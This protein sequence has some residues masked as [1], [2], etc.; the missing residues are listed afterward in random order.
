MLIANNFLM[1]VITFSFDRHHLLY[2]SYHIVRKDG[3]FILHKEYGPFH[4]IYMVEVLL[5]CL[6]MI[7]ITLWHI[8]EKRRNRNWQ[9][10]E[11]LLVA[12]CPTSCYAAEKI[13]DLP[14]DVIPYGLAASMLMMLHLVYFGKIYDLYS[15]VREDVFDTTD[16]ALVVM[17]E[18]NHYKGSNVLAMS[19]IP[20]LKTATIGENIEQISDVFDKILHED[21]SRI[22]FQ[23]KI[24]ESDVRKIERYNQ[25]FGQVIWLRDVTEQRNYLQFCQNYQQKLK[26]EVNRKTT[27]LQ[28][29]QEKMILGFASVIESRDHITGGHVKRT[30]GYVNILVN[31]VKDKKEF[32]EFQDES[33]AK[34]VCLA[35]PL[36]DIGKIGIP[37]AI[38]N[39]KGKFEP[40][41]YEIMK[42]HADLGSEILDK[43]L[44][45][46]EDKE[47]YELAKMM[48]GCHHERWD[49]T[50]YPNQMRGTEIPICARIMAVADVFDALTSERPY[51]REFSVGEAFEII[52]EGR[53]TQFDPDVVDAFLEA[54]DEIVRFHDENKMAKAG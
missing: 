46:L 16:T 7:V 37:D 26:E 18:K 45:S 13:F 9:S 35:A 3:F 12:L 25:F 52:K 14:Y 48:A 32:A 5:Y 4:T 30:S 1:M 21:A 49:G 19:M 34:H 42:E 39:K 40:E 28:S 11:L 54:Q 33:Y 20:E 50:G 23:G 44:S 38:L 2:K 47:Y 10:F 43:T 17:D 24:Y 29:I 51:K 36:H 22:T 6:A 31:C 27:V 15:L 41:E 8:Q 53:G